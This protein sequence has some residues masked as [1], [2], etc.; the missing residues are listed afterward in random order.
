M[1]QPLE[2]PRTEYTRLSIAMALVPVLTEN[3][4]QQ[5]DNHGIF[6]GEMLTLNVN[7]NFKQREPGI[8]FVSLRCH[9]TTVTEAELHLIEFKE[10][11]S[12]YVVMTF[13]PCTLR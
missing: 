6:S 10:Q 13:F 2:D 9:V 7:V 11:D 3:P 8:S 12:E 5:E 4:Q 1:S